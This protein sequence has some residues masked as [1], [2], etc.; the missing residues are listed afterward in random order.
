VKVLMTGD[1][2]GG[3]FTYVCELAAALARRG[4]ETALALL[5]RPL[6][7]EQL[8]ALGRA[9]VADVY[10]R[11]YKLEWMD[12]PWED[13]ERAGRWLLGIEAEVEPDLVHLNGYVHAALPWRAPT[14]VVG[15]SCV[16][17][18]WEAVRREPAPP[19]WDRYRAEVR[20]G[21]T[22]AQLVAAPTAAMLRELRRLYAPRSE[23]IVLPNGRSASTIAGA[24]QPFVLGVGRLW[25][26]AKN[27]AALDAAA[28]SIPW[29]VL[30]AGDEPQPQA[31]PRR[32]RLLGRLS[33]DQ[34]AERFAAASIFAAPAKYEPFGLAA[35]EAGLAGCALVLGDIPSLC[36][37]WDDAAVFVDP[38]DP[39]ALAA[40]INRLIVDAKLR[41]ELGRAAARRARTFTPERMASAYI[42]AYERLLAPAVEPE[43][44]EAVS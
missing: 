11:E 3:V 34:L 2:V 7:A 43:P 40:E 24:K 27:L 4:V 10:A 13:V 5:G 33:D 1:T 32:A 17:S 21:L 37:V 29:P 14:L 18:W 19:E 15:H 36:E 44:L 26:E 31:R 28:A 16:L 20:R 12:E 8:R 41:E 42:D 38:G 9:R 6:A 39:T 35:L 23:T 25:D 30:V 22:A